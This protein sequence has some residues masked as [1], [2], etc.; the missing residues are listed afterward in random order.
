MAGGW[1]EYFEQFPEL[2]PAADYAVRE[3]PLEEVR[4][5]I[6]HGPGNFDELKKKLTPFIAEPLQR[7]N[8]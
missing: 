6:A 5:K 3:T 4:R 7:K 8:R 1:S 2:D